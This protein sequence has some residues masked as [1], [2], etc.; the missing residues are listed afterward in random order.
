MARRR[1]PLAGGATQGETGN[2]RCCWPDQKKNQ[3]CFTSVLILIEDL[4]LSDLV[5]CVKFE[6][7]VLTTFMTRTFDNLSFI[8]LFIILWIIQH[9]TAVP[10]YIMTLGFV[11]SNNVTEI[12]IYDFRLVFPAFSV[13][14]RY[15]ITAL[16]RTIMGVHTFNFHAT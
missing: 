16:W 4:T 7:L 5:S 14:F 15:Y 10:I 2:R 13:R 9:F 1:R 3:L 12:N 8:E 11:T 6:T